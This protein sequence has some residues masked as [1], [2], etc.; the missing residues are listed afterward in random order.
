[1]KNTNISIMLI[2][3]AALLTIGCANFTD[4]PIAPVAPPIDTVTVYGPAMVNLGTA[5]DF[6]I[7]A[8]TAISTVPDSVITGDIGLS[9]A[10]E[11]FMTGFSQTGN[12]GYST[13]NQVT[14]FM[15]A[16]DMTSPTPTKMTTAISD[17]ETAFTDAAGRVTPDF[18]DLYTGALGGEV[19]LPG[20]YK[21]NTS[22]SILADVTISGGANDTWIFQ[23]SGDLDESA[24]KNVILA[25]GAQ[26]KNI[27]W[28]VAGTAT[29]GT[30]AHFEGIILGKTSVTL[31]TGATMNGRVL[32][33]TNVSLDQATVTQPSL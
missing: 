8:K 29:V 33:Q 13:S 19:L 4:A 2:L 24:A 11:S 17:M 9:P 20:L 14:G 22:V 28:Q 23:I 21:W 31:G 30:G 18:I 26:A 15:Y 12:I 6:A 5:G 16:A 27:V 3:A 1:M 32:A 10:A 7:L 25:G